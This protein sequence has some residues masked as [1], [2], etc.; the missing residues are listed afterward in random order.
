MLVT[1]VDTKDFE[2]NED[3]SVLELGK[4]KKLIGEVK[5]H[6]KGLKKFSDNR[7]KEIDNL[8]KELDKMADGKADNFAKKQL[9]KMKASVATSSRALVT[10]AH[11]TAILDYA[12]ATKVALQYCNE[13]AKM[14][15]VS[16]L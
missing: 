2:L 14:Y 11:L 10:G 15:S 1:K 6:G 4:L 12:T 7:L 13:Q 5:T 3:I 16:E 9:L 8:Y